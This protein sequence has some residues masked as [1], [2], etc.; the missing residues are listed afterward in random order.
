VKWDVPKVPPSRHPF[1]D[2]VVS[3]G[4]LA[5]VSVLVGGITGGGWMR[6]VLAAAA[7]FVA[8][9]AWCW[10]RSGRRHEDERVR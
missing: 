6:T 4:L 3:Y 8:E 10:L 2:S 7:F 9:T 1:R 5:L